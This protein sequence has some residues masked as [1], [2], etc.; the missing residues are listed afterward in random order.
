MRASGGR[1]I[2]SGLGVGERP[3]F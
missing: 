2:D 1:L 3:A